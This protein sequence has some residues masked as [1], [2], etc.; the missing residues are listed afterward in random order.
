MSQPMQSAGFTPSTEY[1]TIQSKTLLQRVRVANPLG[2][3]WLLVCTK[4]SRDDA[5]RRVDSQFVLAVVR[6]QVSRACLLF[7]PH[8]HASAKRRRV[9]K[10]GWT[11][12]IRFYCSDIFFSADLPPIIVGIIAGNSRAQETGD[13]LSCHTLLSSS[14]LCSPG[15]IYGR[16]TME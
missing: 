1:F 8:H 13:C 7:P 3:N 9:Q 11:P 14:G 6:P 15:Y 10:V 12:L 5:K 2:Q 4:T 16:S